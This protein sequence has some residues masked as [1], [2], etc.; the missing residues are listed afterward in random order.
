MIYAWY[1]MAYILRGK[2]E[3][4]NA[5]KCLEVTIKVNN[6]FAPA[7]YMKG[8]ILYD[9]DMENEADECHRTAYELDPCVEEEYTNRFN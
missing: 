9:L 7:W 1:D 8:A 2:K 4:H 6:E 5:L 3:D